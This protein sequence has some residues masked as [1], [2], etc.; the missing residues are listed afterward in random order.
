ATGVIPSSLGEKPSGKLG[1]IQAGYNWQTGS[2]ILGI[3]ADID[4]A[5]IAGGG[6]FLTQVGTASW[7]TTANQQ[8]NFL[9]TARG[10]LG[11]TLTPSLLVYGTGGF[12]FGG[13][14]LS[15]QVSSP[16]TA[17]TN[18]A[19]GN[20]SSFCGVGNTSATLK[21]WAAGGGLEYL[22]TPNWS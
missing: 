22:V 14:Q 8:L 4:A 18:P 20:C 9:G 3:E 12:A 1:G 17:F 16:L 21:G 7:T 11:F 5:N 19:G 15:S 10:R 6:N 13:A 2:F